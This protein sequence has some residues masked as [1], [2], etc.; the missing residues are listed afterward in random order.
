MHTAT[1]QNTTDIDQRIRDFMDRKASP[2]YELSQRVAEKLLPTA[3]R[4]TA[5]SGGIRYEILRWR[6]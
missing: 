3:Y 1:K 6:H 5:Q 4:R 2:W